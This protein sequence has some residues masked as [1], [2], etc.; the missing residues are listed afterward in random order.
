M[1]LRSLRPSNGR[2]LARSD[3]WQNAVQLHRLVC[4][5]ISFIRTSFTGVGRRIRSDNQ[6]VS[7]RSFV[8]F[9]VWKKFSNLDGQT[10]PPL[11]RHAFHPYQHP[12][13]FLS[14]S[15]PVAISRKPSPG[16]EAPRVP[17]KPFEGSLDLGFLD[18]V[19]ESTRKRCVV[20]LDSVS[21]HL[22]NPATCGVLDPELWD[23]DS[24]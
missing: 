20:L 8:S 17:R 6:A 14:K 1:F 12:L 5:L 2:S 24:S 10:C 4:P 13:E 15:L 22:C 9:V 3:A 7:W 19:R 18:D 16:R 21:C 23:P 11:Q